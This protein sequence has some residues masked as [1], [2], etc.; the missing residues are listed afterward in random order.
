M[1]NNRSRFHPQYIML[2]LLLA[3]LSMLFLALSA[4][5]LYTRIQHQ[6]SPI[7][8]PGLFFFNTLILLFSSYTLI[9]AKMA[10]EKD[11]T[12]RYQHFLVST[13]CLSLAF[14]G[15]QF[16]AWQQLYNEE[17]YINADL[18]TSYV[19]ALSLLHFVHVLGGIPFL[20]AFVLAAYQRLKEP[21]SVLVYFSDPDKKRFLRLLTIYWH[22]LDLL[23]IYLVV[24]L[25]L[26]MV[27]S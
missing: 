20:L 12:N 9:Q 6:I 22:F 17:L 19:Y 15:L 14:L 5:Y 27:F 18:S 2:T 23:W 24:F 10:Y 26:N 1:D 4:A 11:E 16:I 13:L 7:Q 21:V 8:L 3:G 25:G